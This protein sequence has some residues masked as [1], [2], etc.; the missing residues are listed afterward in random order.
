MLHMSDKILVW[1]EKTLAI[2][3]SHAVERDFGL[4]NFYEYDKQGIMNTTS[5]ESNIYD[6]FIT[7]LD[8]LM[9]LYFETSKERR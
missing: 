2:K 8:V 9:P 7:D 5:K 1:D 6:H 3:L 4:C